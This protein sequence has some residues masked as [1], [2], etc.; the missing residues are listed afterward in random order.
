MTLQNFA[1][2][3]KIPECLLS[4]MFLSSSLIL[5]SVSAYDLTWHW[6]KKWLKDSVVVHTF[7]PSTQDTHGTQLQSQ[8][9]GDAWYILPSPAHR[10]CMVHTSNPSTWEMHGGHLQSQH[11]G[12]EHM[13][14]TSSSHMRKEGS[15]MSSKVILGYI[16]SGYGFEE[17]IGPEHSWV[18]GREQESRSTMI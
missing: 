1:N 8:N 11:G 17:V 9:M 6:W 7:N 16:E 5:L 14:H 13:V 12:G 4:T 3:F 2:P 15:R 10:T 18:T